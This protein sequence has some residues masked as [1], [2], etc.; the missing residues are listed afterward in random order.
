[1]SRHSDAQGDDVTESVLD[2]QAADRA[3]RALMESLNKGLDIT[4]SQLWRHKS[5]ALFDISHQRFI[6]F[7]DCLHSNFFSP[8]MRGFVMF[9][10]SFT[11]FKNL[12]V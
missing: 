12:I 2:F 7:I 5:P 9:E 11:Y 4:S 10:L 1:M 3:K 8:F 6:T